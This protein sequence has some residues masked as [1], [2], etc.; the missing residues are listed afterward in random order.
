ML[1]IKPDAFYP[2]PKVESA[3]IKITPLSKPK[4]NLLNDKSFSLIVR[5]AFSQRRKT[6][7]NSLKNF[8]NEIDIREIDIQPSARAENLSIKD[9]INLSNLYQKSLDN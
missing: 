1:I 6:I 3:I 8:L 7:R 5:E 4:Y 9:F 2:S